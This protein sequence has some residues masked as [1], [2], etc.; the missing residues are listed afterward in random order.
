MADIGC[1]ITP[2]S[3]GDP[4]APTRPFLSHAANKGLSQIDPCVSPGS[5]KGDPWVTLGSPT[6]NPGPNHSAEGHNLKS[7]KRNGR[8]LRCLRY[9]IKFLQEINE[10]ILGFPMAGCPDGPMSRFL[11]TPASPALSGDTPLP[12][13]GSSG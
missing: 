10:V 9:S 12:T 6:P 5:R 11:T 7:T 3:L 1:P 4:D 13:S 2:A 8:P